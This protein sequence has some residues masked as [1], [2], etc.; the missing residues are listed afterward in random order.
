MTESLLS[1]DAV[2]KCELAIWR[3][4]AG[5]MRMTLEN[6]TGSEVP[7]MALQ[8]VCA[9]IADQSDRTNSKRGGE[10]WTH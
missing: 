3:A 9:V 8:R 7:R 1:F 5:I 4:L 10:N 6:W 2:R